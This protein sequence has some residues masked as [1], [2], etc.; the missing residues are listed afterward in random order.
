MG[1]ITAH[2]DKALY[3]TII[4]SAKNTLIADEPENNG[5]QD[6]GF[7]PKELLPSPPWRLAPASPSVC[8]PTEKDGI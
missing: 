5:G 1:K 3:K 6:L 7:A 8:M 4:K 2:I